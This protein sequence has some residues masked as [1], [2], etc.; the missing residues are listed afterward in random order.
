MIILSFSVGAKHHLRQT[1]L[2]F[3]AAP[4]T[5]LPSPA[6]KH[7]PLKCSPM[8]KPRLVT[9]A[10]YAE[11]NPK[12]LSLLL[13]LG[14][15][16]SLLP[17][18]RCFSCLFTSC[19]KQTSVL[20]HPHSA[21]GWWVGRVLP[22]G[23]RRS[24]PMLFTSKTGKAKSA[25]HW[26]WCGGTSGAQASQSYR[27]DRQEKERTGWRESRCGSGVLFSIHIV[28]SLMSTWFHGRE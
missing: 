10:S 26:V 14:T 15:F 21:Q 3:P 13:A 18:Q 28:G 5:H 11:V 8:E 24:S 25:R 1:D 23:C 2:M 4:P 17:V 19:N 20:R 12:C 6:L 7:R 16:L 22:L 27:G 9:G